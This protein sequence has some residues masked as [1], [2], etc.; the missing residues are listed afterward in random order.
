MSSD[1]FDLGADPPAQSAPNTGVAGDGL[2]ISQRAAQAGSMRRV[3]PLLNGLN[4][5]QRAAV[6]ADDGPLLLLAGAGTGK[7]RA[8]TTRIAYKI[9][10][11]AAWPSQILAVTFTNKAAREMKERISGM[12]GETVE[13]MPWLGTFH[14][15]S[16]RIL[17]QHA[18]NALFHFA[19]RFIGKGHG[20][21][22]TWPCGLCGD[23]ISDARGQRARFT[24]SGTGQQQKRAVICRHGGALLVIQTVQQRLDTA[25]GAGLSGAL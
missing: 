3:E 10:T 7:T 21:N 24:G 9:A 16:A 14:S 4:D 23:F 19:R 6:T 1:P 8:L 18:A 2:S 11:Q 12:L 25:H 20:Q 17:R 15:L 13:G 22:L 5:E